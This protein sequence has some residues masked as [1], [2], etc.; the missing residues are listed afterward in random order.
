MRYLA[1]LISIGLVAVPALA[2]DAGDAAASPPA[3]PP[4]GSS[5]P[6][7]QATPPA[8]GPAGS[9]DD[10]DRRATGDD[11]EFIPSEEIPA[12]EEVTFP[13]NI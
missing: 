13:V 6:A 12:D 8:T 5:P 7:E 10:S 1:V 3:S 4:A 11:D 9:G 2:Q